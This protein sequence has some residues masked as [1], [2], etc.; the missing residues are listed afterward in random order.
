LNRIFLAK[1]NPDSRN[2]WIFHFNYVDSD[3][4]ELYITSY[5]YTVTT[6]MT[7]GYGDITAQSIGEKLLA[8]LLMLI[9]VVAFSFATGSISSIIANADSAEDM[10]KHKMEILKDLNTEYNIDQV[11]YN[12]V[13]KALQY[14]YSQTTK[15]YVKL[16]DDL[17]I[18]L[19]LE[20]AMAI[21]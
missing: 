14:G 9:G 7:V 21:H 8:I 12:K 3:V 16:M 15:S 19:R 13:V 10:L 11:L 17:P 5:Y 6:I 18:K 20:L 2:N 4:V 1:F